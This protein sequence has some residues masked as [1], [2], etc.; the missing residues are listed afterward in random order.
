[1]DGT[2]RA[3][4]R[5]PHRAAG[6]AASL[7]ALV[8]TALLGAAAVF[9][10]AAVFGPAR[11]AAA[12]EVVPFGP[13]SSYRWDDGVAASIVSAGPF[14]PSAGARGLGNGATAVRIV[15]KITNDSPDQ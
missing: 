3:G 13:H 12:G 11:P 14:H 5:R 7:L 2:V 9:G 10:V 1:M 15:L 4:H 8:A 6:A